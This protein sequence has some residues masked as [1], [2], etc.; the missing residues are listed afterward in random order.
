M[1]AIILCLGGKAASTGRQAGAKTFIKTNCDRAE[2]SITLT[3]EGDEAYRPDLYGSRITIERKI[4]KD[5][6]SAYKLKDENGR[7][8]SNKKTELDN[9]VDQFNIQV[10]NPVCFLNQETSKHFLNSSNKSDKYKLFMKAS[11]LESMKR[12]Q[13][14]IEHERLSS[15]SILEERESHMPILEDDFFRAEERYKQCQSN[16][17]LNAKKC[18]LNKEYA[19]AVTILYEKQHETLL[20]DKAKIDK[21]KEKHQQK[22]N[23]SEQELAQIE[24]DY[25]AKK[26][27]LAELLKHMQSISANSEEIA[28]RYKK[29]VINFKAANGDIKRLTSQKEKKIKDR[30]ELEKKLND[31]KRENEKDHEQEREKK[32]KKIAEIDAKL[33]EN[34]QLRELKKADS[35]LY[36]K[37]IDRLNKQLD[38]KKWKLTNTETQVRN[39][40]TEIENCKKASKNQIL[41][42]GEYM[43]DLVEDVNR[44]YE[45]RKFRE[46]PRGPIG[47]YIQVKEMEW[48]KA[49][50][51]CIGV[52]DFLIGKYKILDA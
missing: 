3:N 12:L 6:A 23:E 5:G 40:Q 9:I 14:Q 24:G 41:R 50:E 25:S 47:M 13:D 36:Q 37:E 27:E 44:C 46:K 7:L 29:A 22:I 49:I 51:Q 1:D 20:K 8:V 28:A 52:Y 18:E 38:D 43:S 17:T 45:Q 11:Q 10:E 26:S 34:E 35:V 30:G 4:S 48:A 16:E 21:K 15:I 32:A 2:L 39:K 33:K 19:W 42:F 31:Q